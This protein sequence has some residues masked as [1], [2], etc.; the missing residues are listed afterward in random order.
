M[1]GAQYAA[2]ALHDSKIALFFDPTDP[3]SQSIASAFSQAALNSIVVTENYTVGAPQTL[4]GLLQD[5][6]R[7]NPDLIYFAGYPQDAGTLLVNLPAC[8]LSKCLQVMGGDALYDYGDYSKNARAYLPRLHFTAL[9]YPDEWSA[10][11]P[12]QQLPS[13]FSDYPQFFD[14]NK[15]YAPNSVYG[16]TRASGST[17]LS[18]DAMQVL[19]DASNLAFTEGKQTF[20]PGDLQRAL[21]RITGPQ[22]TQGISGRIS[23]ESDGSAMKKVVIVLHMDSSFHTQFDTA[24]GCFLKPQPTSSSNTGCS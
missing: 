1:R 8:S 18:Y 24:Y 3:Y 4:P 19:L 5:A 6:L 11:A 20:T 10:L 9:A 2:E 22:A 12:S 16:Y 21:T 15:Q 13:F 14:P 17:M 23:F 7:Y